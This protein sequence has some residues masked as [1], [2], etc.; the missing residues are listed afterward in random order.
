MFAHVLAL[1]FIL[2]LIA[3]SIS[4]IC[5][6][7][8]FKYVFAAFPHVRIAY[9]I[10]LY[11]FLK[12]SQ[13]LAGSEPYD[14]FSKSEQK[15]DDHY[16]MF[17]AVATIWCWLWSEF[18]SW[19]PKKVFPMILTHPKINKKNRTT[20]FKRRNINA[21]RSYSYLNVDRVYTASVVINMRYA[22]GIF[23]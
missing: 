22:A 12:S 8:L 3:F 18:F 4:F 15:G 17:Q 16:A 5:T 23:A 1:C 14:V 11:I 10:L 7:T 19:V 20:N 6:V 13:R 2:K 21:E 9:F